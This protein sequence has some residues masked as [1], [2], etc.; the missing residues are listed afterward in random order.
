M[1]FIRSVIVLVLEQVPD[2]LTPFTA[3]FEPV[4]QAFA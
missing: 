2:Q 1:I 3:S 4:H